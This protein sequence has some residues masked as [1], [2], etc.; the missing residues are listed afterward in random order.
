MAQKGLYTISPQVGIGSSSVTLGSNGSGYVPNT[1]WA[2]SPIA[3]L[4][5]QSLSS[6]NYNSTFNFYEDRIMAPEIKKYEIYE[7]P[8]DILA[9]SVAWRKIRKHGSSFDITSLLE[10]KLFER[11]T[12]EDRETAN[13]I[14]D[15]YS[16]KIMMWKLKGKELTSFRKDLNTFVH[17]DGMKFKKEMIGLAYYLPEFYAYDSELDTVREQVKT[18]D[19]VTSD[20]KK[21]L[22][23]VPKLSIASKKLTPLKRINR[24]TKRINQMQYWFKDNETDGAVLI[25][26]DS[27]NPLE[28]IWNNIFDN[29]HNLIVKGKYYTKDREDFEYFNIKNWSLEKG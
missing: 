9:L 17:N 8:E 6:H 29:S 5:I 27:K 7:S 28:H 13:V 4:T 1:A 20:V 2:G 3:P 21:L 25:D 11:L 24:V 23:L 19:L 14:R 10:Q 12:V 16:K 15:Y 26:I 18:K 22:P